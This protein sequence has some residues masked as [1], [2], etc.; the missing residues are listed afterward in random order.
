MIS[1]GGV[2]FWQ[3]HFYQSLCAAL[4][5]GKGLGIGLTYCIWHLWQ[6]QI[7][8]LNFH[9]V[10][11]YRKLLWKLVKLAFHSLRH[12]ATKQGSCAVRH[13]K[14]TKD[15]S[16]DRLAT[17]RPLG[18]RSEPF[19][20]AKRPTASYEVARGRA[21]HMKSDEGLFW[22]SSPGNAKVDT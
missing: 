19:L 10:L 16:G 6:R 1:I 13:Q 2:G 22:K 4:L 12:I 17:S 11:L 20:A 14:S 18:E 21:R 15:K 5:G 9:R 7:G 8:G 3:L